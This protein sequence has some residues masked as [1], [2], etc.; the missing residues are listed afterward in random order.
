MNNSIK[1]NTNNALSVLDKNGRLLSVDFDALR[2]GHNP[3]TLG[4][5]PRMTIPNQSVLLIGSCNGLFTVAYASGAFFE[6]VLGGCLCVCA[7]FENVGVDVWVMKGYGVEELGIRLVWYDKEKKRVVDFVIEGWKDGKFEA[8]LCLNSPFSTEAGTATEEG[9]EDSE[10]ECWIGSV[11]FCSASPRASPLGLAIGLHLFY[12]WIIIVCAAKGSS[13]AQIRCINVLQ[14][15]PYPLMN[16]IFITF[17][18]TADL[19]NVCSCHL[20]GGHE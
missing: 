1:T 8:I 10:E 19:A 11:S 13:V 4:E 5:N 9:K 2:P 17:I 18:I 12:L 14:L 7:H 3:V 6:C 15:Q 16:P 20:N